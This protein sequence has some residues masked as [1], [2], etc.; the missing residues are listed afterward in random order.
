MKNCCNSTKNNKKCKRTDGKT[1][2]LPRKFSKKTCMTKKIKGFSMRSY[3]T[4]YNKCMKG[5]KKFKKG[6]CVLSHNSNNISGIIN[7]IEM[8]DGLHIEYNI[9]GL[10]DGLHGFHIHEYGDLSEGCNSGCLHFNP[11]NKTHGGLDGKC[12]HAGDLGNILSTNNNAKGELFVKKLCLHTNDKLS[13][14]G[15]MII[16]HDKE[17]DLGKGNDDESLITGN[18]GARLACGIIGL[19]K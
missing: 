14:L 15:R 9:N 5:G 13:V 1:F 11:F 3:C 17:D 8:I 7:L 6:I 18:S 4:P 16:V 19:K 12:R 10:H 2:K